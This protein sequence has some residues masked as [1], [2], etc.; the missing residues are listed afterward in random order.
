MLEKI[1]TLSDI[2]KL[3]QEQKEELAS[4]IR[5]RLVDVVLK[6]G[7]HLASNLGVTELTIGLYSVIDPFT[8]KVIWD[9]GHQAYV[10][11]ILTG[12]NDA[13]GTLRQ[14]GGI[15]GFPKRNESDADCFET[16]HSST[17]VSAAVGMARA[18]DIKGEKHK[19]VA[20]IG[21]GAF[22]NGMVYE[23]LNDAGTMKGSVVFILNDNGMS[24]ARNVGGI[25]KYF[26]K[27]R[28]GKSYID[29]KRN[30]KSGLDKIPLIGGSLVRGIQRVKTAFRTLTIP[31]EWFEELG[32]KYIG[33]IDGHNIEEVEN[34]LNRAFYLNCPV[35]IHAMTN[36]GYGYAKAEADP[37]AFHG[38]SPKEKL[39]QE[40]YSA[41]MAEELCKMAES[42]NK[43]TAIT[44]AMPSG[45]GLK[46]FEQK[47][48]E[49]FIDVGIAEEHAIT[50]AAGMAA[51]GLKPYVAIYSTFMQRAYDQL[52]HDCALQKLPVVIMLDR[53]GI[54][55][56]DGRTHHGI[57]DIAFLNSVPDIS[58]C[59]PCCAEELKQMLAISNENYINGPFI[60]RYPAKD[61][62]E[63]D[64]SAMQRTQV[65]FGKGSLLLERKSRS[66]EKNVLFITFGQITVNCIKAAEALSDMC[67]VAVFHGRFLK[68]LD[69]KGI[70]S[71]IKEF[72][73]DVIITAEDGVP[74]GG[75]GASVAVLLQK[76]G[77]TAK[78]DMVS[79]PQ[80][81][82]DHGS[83]EELQ[84]QA[85]MDSVGIMK[86]VLRSI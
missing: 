86:K 22:T 84:E 38:V 39:Q 1:T 30:I 40:C 43:I 49:R 77:I 45:T 32:I 85:G 73:P 4:D 8:D 33:P 72:S 2:K 24:I 26:R 67:N 18:R 25:S 62:F 64:I 79:A 60:I 14:F 9:V 41:V 68:P 69:E 5:A 37:S 83:I 20:V 57:Y 31:G 65:E 56:R 61:S 16:G 44:A 66:N 27:I 71:V 28:T 15:S 19:V 12:R 35:L 76:N 7:G 17:S 58:V 6:N 46:K 74:D 50:M 70:L 59:A 23:A 11:K 63:G 48:P 81:P 52:L 36:K 51:A 21:D 47:F 78:F 82:I 80:T 10:H 3:T 42:D 53:A 54:S 75:F 13:F 34:A 55:G 29:A